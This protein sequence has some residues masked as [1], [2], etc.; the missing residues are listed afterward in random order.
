MAQKKQEKLKDEKGTE[1]QVQQENTHIAM[2]VEVFNRVMQTLNNGSFPGMT[3][4][5]VN[6]LFKVV[7]KSG[8]PLRIEQQKQ[9]K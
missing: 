5:Q 8:I 4:A 1:E 3:Y 6:D 9:E 2:P 7:E